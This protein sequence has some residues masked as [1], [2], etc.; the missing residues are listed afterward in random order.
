MRIEM[1]NIHVLSSLKYI[2][3]CI[4]YLD[5]LYLNHF[6]LLAHISIYQISKIIAIDL[7][8][9]LFEYA[10]SAF[11]A[12]SSQQEIPQI[13]ICECHMRFVALIIQT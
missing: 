10:Y 11:T 9:G 7:F 3:I 5:I 6:Y 2:C 4:I 1:F 12:D 13:R 8:R